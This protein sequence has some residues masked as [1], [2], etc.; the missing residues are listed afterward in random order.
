MP[1]I[2]SSILETDIIT[3]VEEGIV[4]K[5]ADREKLRK[6]LAQYNIA[7]SFITT[8][9]RQLTGY[10]RLLNVRNTFLR[11]NFWSKFSFAYNFHKSTKKPNTYVNELFNLNNIQLQKLNEHYKIQ[12][13]KD[14]SDY[15]QKKHE[16]IQIQN[17]I[18]SKLLELQHLTVQNA[19]DVGYN[20]SKSGANSKR[21]TT[22]YAT[23]CRMEPKPL[24][25]AFH[26]M[27]ISA[28]SVKTPKPSESPKNQPGRKKEL[29]DILEDLEEGGLIELT[30]N[31][32][33]NIKKLE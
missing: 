17:S 2:A 21:E 19:V 33:R 8:F 28:D 20:T 18:D 26:E 29:Y 25:P 13:R 6:H 27:C 1:A 23:N 22:I 10:K 32:M 7:A 14:K 15:Q 12:N 11:W 5:P 4:Y 3:L 16:K 30:D 31:G 9:P 24:D